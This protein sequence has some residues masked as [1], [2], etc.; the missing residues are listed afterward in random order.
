[1]ICKNVAWLKSITFRSTLHYLSQYPYGY[2]VVPVRV[3]CPA[4]IDRRHKILKQVQTAVPLFSVHH[5]DIVLTCISVLHN[6]SLFEK[7]Q[8]VIKPI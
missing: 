5:L 4:S 8:I 2:S 3:R 1:M 7:E 6:K